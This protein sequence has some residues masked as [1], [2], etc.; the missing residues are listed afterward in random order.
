MPRYAYEFIGG[1]SKRKT[2]NTAIVFISFPLSW[3]AGEGAVNYRI[4]WGYT[5]GVYGSFVPTNSTATTYE[6]NWTVKGTPYFIM[7][8]AVDAAGVE[9]D[10]SNEVEVY[11]GVSI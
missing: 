9:S 6:V 3:G 5:S 7:V 2:G 10:A 11:N 1:P 8:K 4:Y